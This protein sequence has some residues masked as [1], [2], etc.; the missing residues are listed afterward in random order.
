MSKYL[1]EKG[2]KQIVKKHKVS[3]KGLQ[4]SLST[5]EG[6]AGRN[7]PNEYAE[8][9]TA[10]K[11]VNDISGKL[12]KDKT[13]SANS[14]VT[15]YLKEMQKAAKSE[16]KVVLAAKKKYERES[17]QKGLVTIDVQVFGKNWNDESLRAFKAYVTFAAPGF[18]KVTV[19]SD[20]KAGV[21]GFDDISIPPE[22][23]MK[24]M[25]VSTGKAQVA[26]D[27]AVR[28]K[29]KGKGIMQFDAVQDRDEVKRKA[30]SADEASKKAG[31]T[32]TAGVDFKIFSAGGEVSSEKERKKVHGQEIE[33]TVKLA[34]AGFKTLKQVK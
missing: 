25:A 24:L 6:Y 28:Y 29:I 33:W 3:D 4:S 19:A 18:K 12:L 16:I 8:R 9:I 2:W 10:L 7:D 13:I 21:A 30:T 26:P 32:G 34:K 17:A 1:T 31:A 27:G 14:D 23:A 11:D 20:F 15:K 22:G 5:Y